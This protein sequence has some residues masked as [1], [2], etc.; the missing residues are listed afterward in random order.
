MESFTAEQKAYHLRKIRTRYARLDVDKDGYITLADYELMAKK[1]VEYGKLSKDKADEVYEKF[2]EMAKLIG[3]GE[4]GKKIALDVAIKKAHESLLTLP[5]DQ[6]KSM[7]NNN[8]GKL[9]LAVDTNG[10]GVI[11]ENE[12][13]A[14]FMAVGL[15]KMESKRSFDI[16]DTDK[17]GEI[18]YEEFMNAAEDFYLGMEETELSKAFFG[19]LVD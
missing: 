17:N 16:I 8:A 3:C 4:P 9:F 10:D 6:F 7:L 13:A 11:S 1:M 5:T 15:S 12:F 18:S 19:P 2:R 14:F